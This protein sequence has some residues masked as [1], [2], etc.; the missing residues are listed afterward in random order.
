[1]LIATGEK[2]VAEATSIFTSCDMQSV[3]ISNLYMKTA[4]S[5]SCKDKISR[6]LATLQQ[7]HIKLS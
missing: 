3:A 1:M 4:V 2:K 5:I 7:S 6:S